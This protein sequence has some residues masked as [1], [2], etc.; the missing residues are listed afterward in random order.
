MVRITAVILL[1]K[2]SDARC[3]L[4]RFNIEYGNSITRLKWVLGALTLLLVVGAV[5]WVGFVLFGLKPLAISRLE[6]MTAGQVETGAVRLRA[7]GSV[8]IDDMVIWPEGANGDDDYIIKAGRASAQFGLLSV[9]GFKPRL[10]DVQVSDFVFNA[11]YYEPEQRWN[12]AGIDFGEPSD[13]AAAI[14]AVVLRNGLVKL[15]SSDDAGVRLLLEVGLDF[16]LK[17][18]DDGSYRFA[19]QTGGRGERMAMGSELTGVVRDG[20]LEA[21]GRIDSSD[22][23]FIR[24]DFTME[25]FKAAGGFDREGK[26]SIGVDIRN[27]DIAKPDADE[28]VPWRRGWQDCDSEPSKQI[29]RIFN[30][31]RFWGVGDVSFTVSGSFTEPRRPKVEGMAYCKD[32]SILYSG[33]PYQVDNAVGRVHFEGDS[34]LIENLYGRHG[35]SDIGIEAWAKYGQEQR[36]SQL[37][38]SS[39]NLELCESLFS[40]MNERTQRTVEKFS[41]VGTVGVDLV[42]SREPGEDD[43]HIELEVGLLGVD[44]KF[45]GFAYPLRD[46]K[47][48]L[49]IDS[50]DF[51]IEGFA[52]NSDKIRA[53]GIVRSYK[54]EAVFDID[55]QAS[56]MPLDKTLK[57]SLT[58][59]QQDFYSRLNLAGLL[60]AEAN[61]FTEKA[62][63]EPVF[64]AEVYLK[65][66]ILGVEESGIDLLNAHGKAVFRPGEVEIEDIAGTIA[67]DEAQVRGLVS[68]PPDEAA[69]AAYNITTSVQDARLGEELFDILPEGMQAI[70]S[71]LRPSGYIGYEATLR[72]GQN[73]DEDFAIVVHCRDNRIE[74]DFLR[75][76]VEDIKGDITIT[77]RMVTFDGISCVIR[78][79]NEDGFGHASEIGFS[80]DIGL[81]YGG[82]SEG[83]F[84]VQISDFLID[85]LIEGVLAEESRPAYGSLSPIGVLDSDS[86]TV[87]VSKAYN[88]PDSP[89]IVDLSGMVGVGKLSF[90]GDLNIEELNGQLEIESLRYVVD[91]GLTELLAA[92][93]DGSAIVSGKQLSDVQAVS[94]Y[95]REKDKLLIERIIGDFYGGKVTGVIEANREEQGVAYSVQAA[96][97]AVNMDL[98]LAEVNGVS[99]ESAGRG[100][101]DGSMSLE[102]HTGARTSRSGRCQVE[103]THMRAGRLPLFAKLLQL[104]SSD[105]YAF[106]Q[107]VMDS[108]IR[109][110]ELMITAFDVSGQDAAFSGSGRLCLESNIIDMVLYS[111]GRRLRQAQPSVW[112]SLAEGLGQGVIRIEVSGDFR[113]PIIETKALPFVSDSLEILGRRSTDN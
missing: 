105:D 36:S 42:I 62:G 110:G 54:D 27:L 46:A 55:V 51:R 17:V 2:L 64:L 1:I 69:E 100:L 90:G 18:E 106:D 16:D 7:D 44:A 31:Y 63:D 22:I 65:D 15:G 79:E 97:D 91:E 85:G 68:L 3:D 66:G 72:S 78:S 92:F 10:K 5:L 101:M 20:R 113:E 81:D 9:I 23:P 102:G 29:E 33:F 84:A 8:I 43:R 26:Y 71:E 93:G 56:D 60:D 28:I 38:V 34:L 95:D 87:R 86:L 47:G 104:Q 61:I 50:D 80:G 76:P 40:A 83:E 53:E 41:P 108:F 70:V 39:N 57:E 111:R 4:T 67:G 89:V 32:I 75:L 74:P 12:I 21:E 37:R 25:R 6:S 13:A 82:F 45:E 11:V 49:I 58:Q 98:L 107:M 77:P 52:S 48:K 24:R 103:V 30:E 96:F 73:N 94:R 59:R 14:P 19:L 112:Q 109:N 99:Q 88:E 35:D